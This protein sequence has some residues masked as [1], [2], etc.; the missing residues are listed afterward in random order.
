MFSREFAFFLFVNYAYIG[1]WMH[2]RKTKFEK[3]KKQFS[4]VPSRGLKWENKTYKLKTS[5]ENSV[6]SW[7][8]SGSRFPQNVF[9]LRVRV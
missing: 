9:S 4:G 7:Q 3:K 2:V 5:F 1:T 8:A 6:K